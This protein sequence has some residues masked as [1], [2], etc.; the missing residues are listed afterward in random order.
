MGSNP[1]APSDWELID[2]GTFNGVKKYIRATDDDHGTVSVRYEGYDV[3][4]ILDRNKRA[5]N[6]WNGKIGELGHAAHVPNS[7]LIQWFAEDGIWAPD[8]MEYMARK[9]NDPDWKY[10]KRMPI[11]L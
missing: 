6:D 9:L 8:D 2:D 11:Q 1:P 4:I 7:I 5:Q 10:L 3:P